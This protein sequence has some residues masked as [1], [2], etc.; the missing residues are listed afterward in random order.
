MELRTP[1]GCTTTTYIHGQR[2]IASSMMLVR[3]PPYPLRPHPLP[4]LSSP[5]LNL[6]YFNPAVPH[7]NIRPEGV[8]YLH[9]RPKP[10]AMLPPAPIRLPPCPPTRPPPPLS[11]SAPTPGP[12][13]LPPTPPAALAIQGLDPRV[14]W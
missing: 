8:V 14:W 2:P 13:V 12:A 6:V 4:R 3:C 9:S 5:H 1:R 11:P 7:P 10:F